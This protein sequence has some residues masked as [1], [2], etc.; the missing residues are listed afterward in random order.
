MAAQGLAHFLRENGQRERVL[1][2]IWRN[3]SW[4]SLTLKSIVKKDAKRPMNQEVLNHLI[5]AWHSYDRVSDDLLLLK[6]P[7]LESEIDDFFNMQRIVAQKAVAAEI[8]YRESQ[9]K[10]TDRTIAAKGSAH[11]IM[12]ANQDPSAHRE[13]IMAL[14][15]ILVPKSAELMRSFKNQFPEFAVEPSKSQSLLDVD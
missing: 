1:R 15:R 8:D 9:T 5:E 3:L 13:S 7:Q 4:S 10:A 11:D 14:F 6:S 2:R 12:F